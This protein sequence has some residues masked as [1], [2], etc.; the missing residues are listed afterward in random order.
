MKRHQSSGSAEEGRSRHKCSK[1]S[2]K[3]TPTGTETANL[4]EIKRVISVTIRSAAKA[5]RND[6]KPPLLFN[7][8]ISDDDTDDEE[9]PWYEELDGLAKL[10]PS[11]DMPTTS[12]RATREVGSCTAKLIRRSMM[13]G[14]FWTEM[15]APAQETSDLA[16][17][18]FDRY[19]RLN[20]EFY[21]HDVNKGTGVWGKELDHG[22]LLILERV[23]IDTAYRRCGIG[24]KLVNAILDKTRKKVSEEEGFFALVRPGALWSELSLLSDNP[25]ALREAEKAGEE[26]ALAF[27]HAMGF[28]RVG[29]TSWIAWTDSPDHPSR[30]LEINQ[31]WTYPDDPTTD[32]S[33][34]GEMEQ[35]FQILADPE[36]EAAECIDELTE[37]LPESFA[38]GQWQQTD[39]DGN[40]LLHIAAMSCKPDAVIFLLSKVPRLT[41]VR[42]KKGHT[43]LEALRNR[44]EIVRTRRS[45]GT[46]SWVI[47]DAFEG[48]NSSV[49]TCLATLEHEHIFGLSRL[50][51]PEIEAVLWATDE[52]SKPD[53]VGVQ[54]MLQYK[55]GCTCGQCIGGFLSPRMKLALLCVAEV[56]HDKMHTLMGDTGPDW[57]FGYCYL[58]TH[59]SGSI[60]KKLKK[61]KSMREG[62]ADMFSHFAKCLEW[63]RVPSEDNIVCHPGYDVGKNN[64]LNRGGTMAAVGNAIFLRAMEQDEWAGDGFHRETFEEDID[65]LVAC[66]NDHEF[67]FVAGMCGYDRITPA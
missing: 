6:P 54:K 24:T 4:S 7:G 5:A 49:I 65:A 59:V 46:T 29:T 19:G 9:W 35:A 20:P 3:P 32:V 63:G 17:D 21:K 45:I 26:G 51:L 55:Y 64:Y 11:T 33:P 38:D 39:Q 30:Q 60:Q 41:A 34:S 48:F 56:E 43:A 61:D 67:G 40:T 53:V 28:R 57:V 66:R 2:S 23:E 42:N 37:T 8:W 52:P 16:F 50:S 25:A 62:F 18:L 58:L 12:P 22:D 13:R 10:I 44:L 1:T 27:W 14:W 36:I 31:D 47:S 15:E